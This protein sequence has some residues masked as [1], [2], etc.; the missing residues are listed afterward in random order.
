V[1]SHILYKSRLFRAGTLQLDIIL[2]TELF[3]QVKLRLEKINML[4]FIN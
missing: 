4:F 2:N 3:N 1:A